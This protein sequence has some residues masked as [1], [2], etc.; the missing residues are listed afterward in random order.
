MTPGKA[1]LLRETHPLF[2]VCGDQSPSRFAL[3]DFAVG[4][5]WFGILDDMATRIEQRCA[6][7]GVDL[8]QVVQVK[9]K[10]GLLRVDVRPSYDALHDILVEAERRSAAVCEVCGG[11]GRLCR[12]SGWLR[13]RCDRHV[14][15]R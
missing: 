10:M 11:P 13:T 2:A 4:D 5:G 12:G 14:D 8:P 3:D 9:E 1:R 15:T 6:D 7:T